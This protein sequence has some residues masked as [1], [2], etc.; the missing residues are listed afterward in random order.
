MIREVKLVRIGLTMETG[1]L[2][3][4][5]KE[6]GDSIKEGEPLFEVE[7]DKI[8]T[9]VESFHTGY[10]KKILVQPGEEVPVDSLIAFIGEKDDV[11]DPSLLEKPVSAQKGALSHTPGVVAGDRTAP[12][13]KR[14]GRVN[15][16][17]VAK[18][19]AMELSIDLT[20]V[21]GTGPGGRIGKDDVMAARDRLQGASQTGGDRGG[22]GLEIAFEQVLSGVRKVV[23]QRMSESYTT[24][25]HID[26]EILI[27]MGPVSRKREE[28]NKKRRDLRLTYTDF[29]VLATARSL[30]NHPLLNATLRGD[31]VVAFEPI[32]IGIATDT[33]KGLIVPVIRDAAKLGLDAIASKRLELVQRVRDGKQGA[34]DLRGGTFTVTNLG[35]LGI[36]VFRPILYPGQSGILATGAIRE[37]PIP[38]YRG[39]V[40]FQPVMRVTLA[41]DHRIVD[42]AYGARFLQEFKETIEKEDK[43]EGPN[44]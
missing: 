14:P 7:T 41:C 31:K 10:L 1:T 33:E 36:D 32:N 24:A 34:D 19:L 23:A 30:K 40:C 35:M 27:D 13:A 12:K 17:P 22:E 4:W 2:V 8:T 20:T 42:G 16:S 3:G 38:D 6:E 18:R 28:L 44:G 21:E 5:L 37:T 29:I 43:W 15:A 39:G 11:I 9:V 26:L 25:P